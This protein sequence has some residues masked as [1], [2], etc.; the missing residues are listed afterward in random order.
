MEPGRAAVDR[1]STPE[2][3]AP[4]NRDADEWP[5]PALK[6][7]VKMCIFNPLPISRVRAPAAA[8]RC[9]PGLP[10][11]PSKGRPQHFAV[12]S[13][14]SS[15]SLRQPQSPGMPAPADL[16]TC[17][18]RQHG[19]QLSR[20]ESPATSWTCPFPVTPR[21]TARS[22]AFSRTV[23]GIFSLADVLSPGDKG[24]AGRRVLQNRT[25]KTYW[26]LIRQGRLYRTAS[27]TL[28]TVPTAERP[29]VW[30]C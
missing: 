16:H 17:C 10:N 21:R 7:R 27:T 20:L 1:R 2:S 19:I 25:K 5:F 24:R 8:A 18:C 3:A 4:P 15:A 14:R 13:I 6:T 22:S 9:C 30:K 11:E 29:A 23:C 28:L 12:N 26:R